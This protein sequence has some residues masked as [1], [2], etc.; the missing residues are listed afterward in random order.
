MTSRYSRLAR[1]F[2]ERESVDA[3]RSEFE[4]D[5]DR[6]LYS[7][8]FRRLNGVTQVAAAAETALLHNRLTHSLK[9]GQVGRKI[10][11]NVLLLCRLDGDIDNAC[12]SFGGASASD[13]QMPPVDGWVLEAA[14]MAHDLGHPP[15]GHIAE[16]ALQEILSPVQNERKVE[17][18]LADKIALYP[19]V[20][21]GFHLPDSFEGNAQTFR[22][23]TRLSFR[24]PE[25][26]ASTEAGM[27]LTRATLSA[28]SKYPWQRSV[29]PRTV[30]MRKMKWG[31]YDS[32]RDLLSWCMDGINGDGNVEE[33]MRP[34]GRTIEYRSI[35][36]QVMDWADDITYAIHDV[37]DFY[38]ASLIPLEDLRGGTATADSFWALL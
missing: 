33:R 11:S 35:E 23:L 14:G 25:R 13:S 7:S 10:A 3:D 9:V 32:E 4:R 28:V 38:R 6:L 21:D 30:P 27:N 20:P 15:F 19:E 36:A 1:R 16:A 12:R 34:D 26:S 18:G 22:I 5:R 29:R 17:G 37:E 31:A 8:S 2:A 24:S